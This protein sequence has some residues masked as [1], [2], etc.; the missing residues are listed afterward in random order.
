VDGR[1]IHAFAF[2]KNVHFLARRDQPGV[3]EHVVRFQLFEEVFDPEWKVF[4]EPEIEA[5]KAWALKHAGRRRNGKRTPVSKT[6]VNRYLATLRKAL[7]YAHRKLKI[8][9]QVLVVEQYSRDEGT[10]DRLHFQSEGV[11]RLDWDCRRTLALGLDSRAPLRHLPERDAEA[12]EGLR[13]PA[14]GASGQR[15][16]FGPGHYQARFEAA[17]VNGSWSLIAR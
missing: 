8:I 4:L 7:R 15:N 10:R 16:G 5:F 3:I 13:T 14:S 2:L 12:D 1:G 17:R 6:T 11:Q 9:D